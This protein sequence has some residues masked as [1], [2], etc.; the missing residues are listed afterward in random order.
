MQ[1]DSFSDFRTAVICHFG[2]VAADFGLGHASERVLDPEI[3]MEFSGDARRL[4]VWFERGGGPWVV[5]CMSDRGRE[6]EFGLHTLEEDVEG[7]FN[8]THA[9]SA[10]RTVDEQVRVLADLTRRYAARLLTGDLGRAVAVGITP[11]AALDIVKAFVAAA[12]SGRRT[13][14]TTT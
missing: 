12:I 4:I 2:P 5:V 7:S 6:H 8:S 10:L 1:H 14:R 13:T 11:F 3:C 9:V